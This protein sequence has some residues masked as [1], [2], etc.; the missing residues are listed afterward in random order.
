MGHELSSPVMM[1]TPQ[2]PHLLSSRGTDVFACSCAL[3]VRGVALVE[4]VTGLCGSVC[5]SVYSRA[6]GGGV[7]NESSM[8]GISRAPHKRIMVVVIGCREW[9]AAAVMRTAAAQLVR[10]THTHTHTHSR[11]QTLER[12]QGHSSVRRA[13]HTLT[14]ARGSRR[15]M[16]RASPVRWCLCAHVCGTHCPIHL[17][18]SRPLFIFLLRIHTPGT[19]EHNTVERGGAV[20]ARA[21]LLPP[22]LPPSLSLQSSVQPA[23]SS[24]SCS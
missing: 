1:A 23:T 5:A 19:P 21:P 22:S 24:S 8:E 11:R 4:C 7:R 16:R 14:G 15:R 10:L 9:G 18:H 12:T 13:R 20:P 17:L 3:Q 2:G 6:V